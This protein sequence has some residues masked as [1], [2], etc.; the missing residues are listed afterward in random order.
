MRDPFQIVISN[1]KIGT[2]LFSQKK[3]FFILAPNRSKIYQKKLI[4][5][6]SH[7]NLEY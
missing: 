3:Y 2:Y 7:I 5:K 4:L 6:Y 1:Y